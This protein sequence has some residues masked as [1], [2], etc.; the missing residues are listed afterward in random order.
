MAGGASLAD[1]DNAF[2]QVHK[3]GKRII[4]F[5]A[6]TRAAAVGLRPTMSATEQQEAKVDKVER[7]REVSDLMW[8]LNNYKTITCACGTKLKIP[9][10]LKSATIKCP[11][12]G[13]INRV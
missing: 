3:G 1:Y 11:H 8:H 7:T 6:V 4:P 2:R 10:N 5:S 9:P 12:C 13:R